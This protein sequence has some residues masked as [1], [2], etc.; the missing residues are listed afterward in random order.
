M[1]LNNFKTES[2]DIG[3]RGNIGCHL[4]F[5]FPLFAI[6]LC[7]PMPDGHHIFDTSI[8]IYMPDFIG[9][10]LKERGFSS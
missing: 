9:S 5:I 2:V 4:F 8:K 3:R 7:F 6:F 10:L 1:I